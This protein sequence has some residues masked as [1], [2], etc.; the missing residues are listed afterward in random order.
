LIRPI[1]ALLAGVALGA[2]ASPDPGALGAEMAKIARE[3]QLTGL[4]W[5]AVVPD[6]APILGATGRKDASA[7]M[8]PGTRVHVGSVAKAVLAIGVLRLVTEGRLALDAPVAGLLPE[9]AFDNAW[10]KTHPVRVSHLLAH[11]AGIENARLSQV[12]SLRAHAHAPLGEALVLPLRVATAPGS[13]FSYSNVGYTLLGLV[14]EKVTRQ[15]YEAWLDAQVLR[16]LGMDGSTFEYVTQAADARLAMGHFD[17]GVP[18]AAVPSF[19]RPAAQFTT[20]AADMA[21]F[22][23]FLMG[24]GRVDGRRLVDE[25]L[26]A[27][28]AT[29]EATDAAA[30]GLALGHGLALS[31]RD[32]NGALGAC[33]AGTTVGFRAMLCIFPAE[34]KAY[35]YS[36]NIDSESARYE[37]LDAALVAALRPQLPPRAQARTTRGLA[38]WEGYYVPRSNG[39][40]PFA[41]ADTLFHAVRLQFA[42]GALRLRTPSGTRVLEPLGGALFRAGDRSVASHALVVSAK[43]T[44]VLET[45]VRSYEQMPAAAL[46]LLWSSLIAGL[47]GLAYLL[48]AGLFRLVRR[49]LVFSDALALPFAAILALAIPVPF[50]MTQPFLALGDPTPASVLLA[51]ATALLPAAMIVGLWRHVRRREHASA[52]HGLEALAMAA[53]LQWT[54]VLGLWGLMPV[55]LWT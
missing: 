27:R 15:R 40:V 18:Q 44:R 33:H 39:I 28:L 11:T 16:P 30:A 52:A 8:E 47:V 23:R 25:A 55:R 17:R 29:P 43:G 4:V 1:A 34:G 49:R 54:F 2:G 12:F 5:A 31:G 3:E 36:A 45:G 6:A 32:R 50:F 9:V 22:A 53:V 46:A 42:E 35:F 24:D 38:E 20:T 41:Y 48:G 51:L 26:L 7:A 10:A 14:I 37:R 13:R 19:L 21:A